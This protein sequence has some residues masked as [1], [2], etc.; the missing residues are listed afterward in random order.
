M[1]SRL[2]SLALVGAATSFVAPLAAADIVDDWN[3]LLLQG[4][5]VSGGEYGPLAP[6]APG[7]VSRNAALM[8]T[9]MHDAM[10]STMKQYRPYLGM[11]PCPP[12]TD[13]D[14]ALATAAHAVLATAYP[15]IAAQADALLGVHLD[16]IPDGPDKDAGMAL[17]A[18]CAAAIQAH[19]IDDGSTFDPGYVPGNNPGD[20]QP[21]P[22]GFLEAWGPGWAGCTTW[23]IDSGSQFSPAGPGGFT[24]MEALLAS[25]L[26]TIMYDDAKA[27]GEL[28][29]TVRTADQTETALFWS[30]DRDGTYKPPGHLLDITQAVAI[31]QGLS[32]AEKVRLYALVALG[33]ADAGIAAWD[34]KYGT[35]IDL[36]RPLTAI[37]AAAIDGNRD[38]VADPTWI[39]LADDPLTLIGTPPFPAWVSG[40]ATFGAVHAA[41]MRNF[42]GTDEVT[43]TITSDDTPGVYRTFN[44]F[45]DAALENGRSRVYLGVHWQF[46]ADDGYEIGTAVGD[47]VWA[48]ELGLLG[49]LDGDRDVDA[50]DLGVLL[51]GWSGAGATDLNGDGVTDS[52]DLGILLAN[53][54]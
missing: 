30:N 38:T 27:Y 35:E 37:H 22:P 53:W 41:I 47:M 31:D 3:Q 5:R 17:G 12:G 16:T 20:W 39:P 29:S 1:P 28:F 54:T 15:T 33:L 32:Q 51:G 43:F 14:A 6:V 49:D 36:W 24:S 25:D 2:F 40:H 52:G 34:T 50:E 19:R 23:C 26:Y 45:T 46:D 42:F 10:T 8:F 44:T 48:R 21:T 11:V 4:I 13:P 9:A 7:P 18:A